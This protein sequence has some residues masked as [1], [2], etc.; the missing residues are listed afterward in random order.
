MKFVARLRL[1]SRAVLLIRLV[2][3][4]MQQARVLIVLVLIQA[5]LSLHVVVASG[6][7]LRREHRCIRHINFLLVFVAFSHLHLGVEMRQI[8]RFRLHYD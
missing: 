2:S 7:A 6:L 4:V 8:V 3:F 5:S 1:E